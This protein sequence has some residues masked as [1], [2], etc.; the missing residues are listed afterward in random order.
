MSTNVKRYTPPTGFTRVGENLW[1]G[2][3]NGVLRF[4]VDMNAGVFPSST[5][6]MHMLASS[7]GFSKLGVSVDGRELKVNLNLGVDAPPAKVS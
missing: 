6:K 7:G 1:L 5:G 4:E 2:I 3:S